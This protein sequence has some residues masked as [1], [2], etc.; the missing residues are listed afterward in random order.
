MSS[1]PDDIESFPAVAGEALAWIASLEGEP[2]N[3]QARAAL[4]RWLASS[5]LHRAAFADALAFS[6]LIDQ[7][8]AL[9][10][11]LDAHPARRSRSS[12][13]SQRGFRALLAAAGRWLQADMRVTG[14]AVAA[15]L[16]ATVAV[17]FYSGTQ[18]SE[19]VTEDRL[20]LAAADTVLSQTL[21]DGGVLTAGAG[22]SVEIAY[23][24]R[25]RRVVLHDG[26]IVVETGRD[27]GRPFLVE[28]AELRA[29][30]LGTVFEVRRSGSGVR[31]AVREGRVRLD[32]PTGGQTRLL[33]PG[34]AAA[35]IDGQLTPIGSGPLGTWLEGRFIYRDVPLAFILDDIQR[36]FG[37]QVDAGDEIK[38]RRFTASFDAEGALA[39]LEGVADSASHDLVREDEQRFRLSPR[40]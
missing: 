31:I 5:S 34:E 4:E 10:L 39:A 19:G 23:D 30:A 15:A 20:V 22:S 21:P 17:I 26:D 8:E 9:D 18:T 3:L 37:I 16:V 36:S 13:A 1:E 28:A 27:G 24:A 14:A 11:V 35:W 40:P 7:A 38:N 12:G 6:R 29:T 32:P 25:E 2:E 33:Q